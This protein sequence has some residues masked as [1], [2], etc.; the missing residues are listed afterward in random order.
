MAKTK[1]QETQKEN[2]RRNNLVFIDYAVCVEKI[3]KWCEEEGTIRDKDMF[4][5]GTRF[6]LALSCSNYIKHGIEIDDLETEALEACMET[7][8]KYKITDVFMDM[9]NIDYMFMEEYSIWNNQI[10]D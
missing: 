4:M 10:T 6:A 5:L 1:T 9:D 3:C 8:E 2:L 7:I